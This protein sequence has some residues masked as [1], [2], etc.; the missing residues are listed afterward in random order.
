MRIRRVIQL[1]LVFTMLL[2]NKAISEMA[3]RQYLSQFELIQ[4][5]CL[6][7]QVEKAQYELLQIVAGEQDPNRDRTGRVLVWGF[8][9]ALL[10]ASGV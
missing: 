2:G 10:A 6:D 7:S 4:Y 9:I 3:S 1:G 5:R 8:H